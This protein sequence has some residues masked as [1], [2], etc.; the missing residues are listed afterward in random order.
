[1]INMEAIDQEFNL[2]QMWMRDCIGRMCLNANIDKTKCGHH[3]L[4]TFEKYKKAIYDPWTKE[5]V[6]ERDRRVFNIKPLF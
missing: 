6:A 4:Y 5:T 3:P 2:V 1:M